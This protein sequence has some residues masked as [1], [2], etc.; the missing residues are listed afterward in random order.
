M[1]STSLDHFPVEAA[2]LV[3]DGGADAE[4]SRIVACQPDVEH[5][6]CVGTGGHDGP[7]PRLE[8]PFDVRAV[9]V[10]GQLVPDRIPGGGGGRPPA[11]DGKLVEAGGGEGRAGGDGGAPAE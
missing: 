10:E 2:R 8:E 7:L 6:L 1:C 11:A 4:V 9:K 5:G 3:L